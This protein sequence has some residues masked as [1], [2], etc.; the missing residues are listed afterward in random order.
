MLRR[1]SSRRQNA[2]GL[3]SDACSCRLSHL[4][5]AL[6]RPLGSAPNVQ[7]AALAPALAQHHMYVRVRHSITTA[8]SARMD[9]NQAEKP[10]ARATG[11]RLQAGTSAFVLPP[12]GRRS[13]LAALL[14]ENYNGRIPL[15]LDSRHVQVH[16]RIMLYGLH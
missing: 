1:H 4:S 2:P 9:L 5:L 12:C 14:C 10:E 6:H 16:V 15:R 13:A 11:V 3:L 8:S 7:A